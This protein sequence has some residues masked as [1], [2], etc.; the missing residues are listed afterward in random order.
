MRERAT[1]KI[2][3]MISDGVVDMADVMVAFLEVPYS[4]AS[5]GSFE[6]QFAK[7]H[8]KRLVG[9]EKRELEKKTR[10]RFYS[11]ISK[12]KEDGLLEK[13][14]GDDGT[15]LRIT[16]LGKRKFDILAAKKSDA[17]PDPRYPK[18][19][20][21]SHVIVAFDVPEKERRKRE[22]LRCALKNLEF[23]LIQQSVWIGKTKIPKGF[24]ED[25]RD[26]KLAGYVEI[27]EISKK[28]TLRHVA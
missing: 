26:M 3:E 22:W 24:L 25:L 19:K 28:G 9:R 4:G 20:D 5:I 11:M 23:Q 2:L 14:R 16:P 17:L 1:L 15:F 8:A 21:G 7:L 6:Y 13:A 10:Q 18:S 12:L 27:F